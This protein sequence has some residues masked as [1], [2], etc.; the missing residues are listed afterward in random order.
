MVKKIGVGGCNQL[1]LMNISGRTMVT[2]K[3]F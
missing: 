2:P 1:V 3:R